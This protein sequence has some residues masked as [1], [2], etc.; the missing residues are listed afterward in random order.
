LLTYWSPWYSSA[1]WCITWHGALIEWCPHH[2]D[3]EDTKYHFQL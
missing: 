1:V 2:Y 3:S